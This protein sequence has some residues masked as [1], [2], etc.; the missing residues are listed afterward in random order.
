ML[1]IFKRQVFKVAGFLML[2][3]IS[4][5]IKFG[6][7]LGVLKG[8]LLASQVVMPLAG[9]LTSGIGLISIFVLSA[10]NS[11]SFN[12]T[13]YSLSTVYHIPSFFAS[14]SLFS[15]GNK[16]LNLFFRSINFVVPASC[17]ILFV[18]N[19]I[20]SQ[21]PAYVLYW[22]IPVFI[23]ASGI[24]NM[25]LKA[26]SATFIAHA[27]GTVI[28]VYSVPSDVSLWANLAKIVWLERIVIALGMT[29]VY[30][31][32]VLVKALFKETENMIVLKHEKEII[33]N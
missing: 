26:L 30:K 23:T 25:F 18:I 28:F 5:L 32:V 9:I 2:L 29:V 27:V 16:T 13:L 17:A 12:F 3:F 1:K 15:H 10:I 24:E 31:A 21:I 14:L 20:G 8:N 4:K 11:F 33:N 6:P 22:L 7:I 19:P